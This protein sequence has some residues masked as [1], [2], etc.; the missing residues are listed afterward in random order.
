MMDTFTVTGVDFIAA[1]YIWAPEGERVKSTY[2]L[3]YMCQQVSSISVEGMSQCCLS[4]NENDFMNITNNN[5]WFAY[6]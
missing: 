4:L 5:T 6:S 3:I 2:A 1:F